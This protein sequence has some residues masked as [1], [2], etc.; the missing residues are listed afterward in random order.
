MLHYNGN[1]LVWFLLVLNHGFPISVKRGVFFHS[2]IRSNKPWVYKRRECLCYLNEDCAGRIGIAVA[3][4]IIFYILHLG[5]ELQPFI[6]M[7][8]L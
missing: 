1:N 8:V 5:K 6:L 2:A 3:C 4:G 7:Q